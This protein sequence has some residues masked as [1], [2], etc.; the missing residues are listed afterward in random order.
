GPAPTPPATP[1]GGRAAR[2][3]GPRPLGLGPPQAPRPADPRGPGPPAGADHRRHP[4]PPRPLRTAGPAGPAA[5]AVRAALGQRAVAARLQGA[6]RGR[7]P[8]GRAAGGA[9]RPQPLLALPA[10]LPRPDVRHR[11]GGAVGPLRRRRAARG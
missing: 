7:P 1:R 10:A 9:G 3:G 8:A 5:A 6:H 4:P 11:A 2:A